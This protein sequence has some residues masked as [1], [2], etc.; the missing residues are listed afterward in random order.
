MLVFKL[1]V[2]FLFIINFRIVDSQFIALKYYRC[3]SAL[4]SS[5]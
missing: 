2:A 5:K 1:K 4:D 3:C